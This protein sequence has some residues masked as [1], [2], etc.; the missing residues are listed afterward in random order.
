MSAAWVQKLNESDSRLHKEH[1]LG[2]AL[3]MAALGD[4]AADNFLALLSA[5]YN[6][7]ITFGIKQVPNTV[8]IV[9][10]K[11]PWSEFFRLLD[12][13]G[14]RVLTGNRARL[15]IEELSL[16]FNSEEWNNFCAPV[17]RRDIRCGVSEKTINKIC[18]NTRYEIPVFGCQLATNCEGRPEMSGVKRLE[19]KLDGVR[20]LM[21]VVPSE[22]GLP[23]VF[24][25]SR[26]GKLFE[27]FGHIEQQLA[28]NWH[29][30]VRGNLA[31]VDGFI[32]DGEIMGKSFQELMKQAQRKENVQATDSVF[33]I[34]DVIPLEDFRRGHW[35]TPLK[36]RIA[37]LDKMRPVIDNPNNNLGNVDLLP[38]IIVDLDTAAG[39]DQ[40]DRYAQ[41]MVA[42]GFEGIM[43][44]SIDSPYECKRNTFWL[45]FKPV[46]DYD[47]KV[48]ALEEGTGKNIG[49]LG[50]L[51][52]EGLDDGKLIRVNVGSG[53]TDV[54]RGDYW[55]NQSVVI[56]Q[57][58]VVLADAV[59][60]SQDG[61]YSLR[62]PRFKTFR[63][64]K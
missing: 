44:K 9:A 57:T 18:R 23:S 52:C 35:N 58:A 53:F 12:D 36:K 8:D 30:L 51:I 47:L 42:R 31:L 2:Q 19:P 16:E 43:I 27:N 37:I 5:T 63:T 62:F 24:C 28:D 41:D 54:Q 50:A 59:T 32:L 64:D 10:G 61:T 4:Q 25:Y 48:V 46:Y 1:I 40:L 20:A 56:G 3:S 14:A 29:L 39:H 7:Y 49:R 11:N 33:N 6:P 17:I 21:M 55:Q 13:L 60:Q 38:H 34:F 22:S 26:N 45:K 15:R